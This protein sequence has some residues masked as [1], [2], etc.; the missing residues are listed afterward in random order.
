M[1]R[2]DREITDLDRIFD[3]LARCEVLHLAM[4]GDSPDGTPYLVPVNFGCD[5]APE[6]IVL[7]FHAAREGRKAALLRRNP[8]VCFE[9]E[10][11]LKVGGGAAACSWTCRY[12]SVAGTAEVCLLEGDAERRAGLDCLMRHYGFGGVP[13]YREKCLAAAAVYRLKVESITGKT[14]IRAEE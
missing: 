5:R 12:E 6:G 7:Y 9:A 11:I 2:S 14:N 13:E 1:R 3:V 8:H 4:A 10:R